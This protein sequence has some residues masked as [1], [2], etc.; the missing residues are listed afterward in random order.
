MQSLAVDR[1]HD[2]AMT[3]TYWMD[4]S[5]DPELWIMMRY[6][7]TY[8]Y[9]LCYLSRNPFNSFQNFLVFPLRSCRLI[10]LITI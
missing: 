5:M 4:P 6:I 7:R 8:R 10:M 2:K 1:S 3:A 9:A